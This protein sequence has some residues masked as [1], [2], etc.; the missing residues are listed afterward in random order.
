M[1][2]TYAY[3]RE[4]GTPYYIGKGSG[5]RCYVPHRGANGKIAIGLPPRDRILIMKQNLTEDEAFKHERYMIALYGRK[6]LNT[7][8]LRNCSDGGGG[9]YGVVRSDEFRKHQSDY[10]KENNPMKN[11]ETIEKMRKSKIGSRQ[12][13]ETI[14]K[15]KETIRKMGGVKLTEEQKQKISRGN[16]GKKKSPEHIESLRRAQQLRWKRHRGEL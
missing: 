1:F 15:R 14:E 12:S 10:L 16:K 13:R 6:D 9:M 3:L 2:Y 4:D 8:I 11:P 5:R 7:G